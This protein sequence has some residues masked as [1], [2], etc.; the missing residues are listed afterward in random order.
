MRF[1]LLARRVGQVAGT[2]ILAANEMASHRNRRLQMAIRSSRKQQ[3]LDF[4]WVAFFILVVI[5]I[6]AWVGYF[7]FAN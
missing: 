7:A 3:P 5:V 1:P 6:V 4:V 2:A